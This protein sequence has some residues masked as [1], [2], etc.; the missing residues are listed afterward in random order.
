MS[1]LF[2]ISETT[3]PFIVNKITDEIKT[4]I[5]IALENNVIAHKIYKELKFLSKDK[6][7]FLP[8]WDI[9]LYEGISPSQT[10]LTQR[11]ATLLNVTKIQNKKIVVTTTTSLI[12][13]IPPA[14][15]ISKF[16]LHLNKNTSKKREDLISKLVTM[17]YTR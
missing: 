8:E 12:Q 5:I 1:E 15:E 14:N 6:V 10:I 16:L 13:K 2:T 9:S 7:C 17:G 11:I 3:L 4:D